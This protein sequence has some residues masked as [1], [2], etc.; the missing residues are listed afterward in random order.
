MTTVGVIEDLPILFVDDESSIL[1]AL[2]R[3][4]EA[5]GWPVVAV[6][7]PIQALKTI[8]TREY[9]VVVSDFRMPQM[10]GVDFLAR[11]RELTP[12]TERILLTAYADEEALERGINDAGI[13]RFLRKPWKREMLVAILGQARQQSRY[14]REN[15]LLASR[16]S[17]RNEELSYLNE[18]LKSRVAESDVAL[19]GFRRR[20]DAALNA[21]SD[22]LIMVDN[23]LRLE[24]ANDA[25]SGMARATIADMEGR[26]CHELLFKRSSPCANCPIGKDVATA[27]VTLEDDDKQSFFDVR[28]YP[29]PASKP[30]HLCTYRDVTRALMLERDM[31][32][33]DKMAAIGRLAGGVAHEIN[34]P[35]HGIL[36]F[37]QL[38]QK[39]DVPS[40]KLVRYHDVI[41]ECA[42][43]CRDIVQSLR[44]FSRQAKTTERSAV[45]LNMVCE[46]ALVLFESVTTR[47]FEHHPLEGGASGFGN[48]NQLQQV[49]VNL[50]HNAIDASPNN[51]VIKVS[52]E[53]DGSDWV[54]AVEDQGS[55]VPDTEARKIFE[56]FYTT[57]PQGQGTGLGLAISHNIMREH[58]GSLRVGRASIGGAR[59]EV[60]L[61]R[62]VENQERTA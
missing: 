6:S 44:D 14:R 13:S 42:L 11:V 32:N 16:L 7:S 19:Q 45:E 37:V 3:T 40:E 4:A 10:D 59:F 35:L 1:R 46:K 53:A 12:E 41:K 23:D 58:G 54:I 20:W 39:P 25:A 5:S 57:K 56:P 43:R 31:S 60:R 61:P 38:A 47:R 17:N 29:L 21:I 27:R 33:V 30:T 51:G 34:N 48:G 26:K 55:G 28:A 8:E 15:V 18:L 50:I 62:V 24:G 22:P 49:L 2:E 9:S 52:V 36:S